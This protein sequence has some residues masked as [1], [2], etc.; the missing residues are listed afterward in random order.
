[1][2]ESDNRGPLVVRVLLVVNVLAALV[3]AC[4]LYLR[5]RTSANVGKDDFMLVIGWVSSLF[6]RFEPRDWIDLRRS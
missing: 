2:N 4:R 1:M 3:L 6:T 5:T